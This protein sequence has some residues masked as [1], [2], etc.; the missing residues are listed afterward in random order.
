MA[1]IFTSLISAIETAIGTMAPGTGYN[2]DYGT[3]DDFYTSSRTFPSVLVS[4]TEEN[5]IDEDSGLVDKIALS[6]PI[7][8]TVQ[9]SSTQTTTSRDDAIDKA[10][11]DFKRMFSVNLTTLQAA[12][13]IRYAYTSAQRRYTLVT[14]RPCE[15]DIRFILHWRQ[16]RSTPSST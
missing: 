9:F 6:T 5:D 11:D 15:V 16:S 13:L 12:G 7:M 2:F 3:I 1:Q 10:I 4:F 8:F 14:A